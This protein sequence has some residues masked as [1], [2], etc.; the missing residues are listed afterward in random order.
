MRGCTDAIIPS[1]FSSSGD[2]AS[3]QRGARDKELAEHRQHQAQGHHI[4]YDLAPTPV[5]RKLRQRAIGQGPGRRGWRAPVD[6]GVSEHSTF[7]S[8]V[9]VQ[10]VRGVRGR[11][12]DPLRQ[13]PRCCHLTGHGKLA[14]PVGIAA[15]GKVAPM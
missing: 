15:L 10:S 3:Q 1:D 2:P 5:P 12:R 8:L 9:Y 4:A 11:S 6:P 13:P 7:L 14:T